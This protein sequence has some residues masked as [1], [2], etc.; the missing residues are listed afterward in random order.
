VASLKPIEDVATAMG[1]GAGL[2]VCIGLGA[3]KELP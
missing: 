2:A 3:G 1:I